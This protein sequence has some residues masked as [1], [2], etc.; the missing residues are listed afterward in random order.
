MIS[1]RKHLEAFS[2]RSRTAAQTS[3]VEGT[4]DIDNTTV[5]AVCT[6][7]GAMSESG[8]RAVPELGDELINNFK[9]IEEA[10]TRLNEPADLETTSN[11]VRA[12]L[13][14]WADRAWQQHADNERE[15]KEI[16]NVVARATE[17]VA[18]RDQKYAKQ[19]GDVGTRLTAIAEYDDISL[20]RRA[21]L[22]S[23]R[24]LKSCVEKMTEES[25][26]TMQKLTGEVG[27]YR[28]RLEVA[29]R[30]SVTDELTRL[31]NRRAFEAELETRLMGRQTFSVIMID[32]NGFKEINDRYGHLAGDDL[33]KQFAGE[34]RRILY[35][36]SA[37][38]TNPPLGI[39]R[40]QTGRRRRRRKSSR[41]RRYR[42]S[43]VGL[44][45]ERRRAPRPCGQM[46]LCR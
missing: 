3:A 33:L 26:Q 25:R 9:Q 34:L 8:R 17:T 44:G 10:F 32:L 15:I 2:S 20:M 14:R 18:E 36:R 27:D 21:I 11:R 12:E 40:L 16:I 35:R 24:A 43:R 42:R 39:R 6:M 41:Q 5:P 13:T 29:E 23:T 1:L 45:R 22:E 31:S 37:R 7:L 4:E 28:K 46:P 38:G 19:I 30:I